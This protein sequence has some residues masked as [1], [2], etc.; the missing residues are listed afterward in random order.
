VYFFH[1]ESNL[2]LHNFARDIIF[3][4]IAVGF[5]YVRRICVAHGTSVYHLIWKTSTQIVKKCLVDG[6]NLYLKRWSNPTVLLPK[7]MSDWKRPPG[8][9]KSSWLQRK[10]PQTEVLRARHT[11]IWTGQDCP[12]TGNSTRRETKKRQTEKTMERQHQRVDWLVLSGTNCYGKLKTA[13]SGGSWLQN[14]QWG[15]KGRLDYGIGE[16]EGGALPLDHVS[17]L[18]VWVYV[19]A[20]LCSS[21]SARVY[22]ILMKNERQYGHFKKNSNKENERNY[23]LSMGVVTINKATTCKWTRFFRGTH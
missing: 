8:H 1:Y 5:I 21:V 15:P 22:Q 23:N 14:L 19:R 20:C 13:R 9:M 7:Q 2:C 4:V 10:K 3:F 6:G 12:T 16:G 17:A 11:N 18:Y